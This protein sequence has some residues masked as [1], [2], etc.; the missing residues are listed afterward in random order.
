MGK[1]GK[2]LPGL[3]PVTDLGNVIQIAGSDPDDLI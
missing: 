2:F 3:H 1:H